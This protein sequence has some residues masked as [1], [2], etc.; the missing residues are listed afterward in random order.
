MWIRLHASTPAKARLAPLQER[1]DTLLVILGQARQR[2]LVDV[3]VTGE[4]VERV[5]PGG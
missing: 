3:H 1:G 4:V 5:L 2:E